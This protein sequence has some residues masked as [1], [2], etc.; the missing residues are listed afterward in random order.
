MNKLLL[1]VLLLFT[2]LCRGQFVTLYD[3]IQ[4]YETLDSSYIEKS[5]G[6]LKD[7]LKT[8]VWK[9]WYQNGNLKSVGEY[10][11][12]ADGMVCFADSTGGLF[13]SMAF[14]KSYA[15]YVSLKK[16]EWKTYYPTGTVQEIC[17][18][19]P[20]VLQTVYAIINPATDAIQFNVTQPE[21]TL[22]GKYKAYFENGT[23]EEEKTYVN[24]IEQ[25]SKT[26]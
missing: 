20:Y 12:Y 2:T 11:P 18:Y 1:P 4:S 14:K 5:E 9:E 17:N 26:E 22:T 3:T 24:G 10:V 21:G 16:G 8:G 23:L 7:G 25:E 15:T 19:L 6:M 13:D